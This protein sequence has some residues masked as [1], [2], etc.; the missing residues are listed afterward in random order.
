MPH[1]GQAGHLINLSNGKQIVTDR[2][3]EEGTDIKFNRF[4]GVMGVP[5]AMV[6]SITQTDEAAEQESNPA[7]EIREKAPEADAAPPAE[8][9]EAGPAAVE[10]ASPVPAEKAPEIKPGPDPADKEKYLK[11]RRQLEADAKAAIERFK[12]LSNQ[13]DNPER[14]AARKTFSDYSRQL[15]ELQEELKQKYQGTLPQ[16]WQ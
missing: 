13:K 3:W 6:T 7:S 2:Y 1:S 15:L 16:W 12:E 9:A 8:A 11:K 10:A 14:E 5:K 4:G